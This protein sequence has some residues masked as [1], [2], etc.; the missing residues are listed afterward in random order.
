MIIKFIPKKKQIEMEILIRIRKI[1]WQHTN[2]Y[3]RIEMKVIKVLIGKTSCG[4]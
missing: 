3:S 4:K 2:Y 1:L